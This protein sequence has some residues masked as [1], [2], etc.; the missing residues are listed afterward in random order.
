MTLSREDILA[1]TLPTKIE[2]VPEWGGKVILQGITAAQR[3]AYEESMADRSPDGTVKRRNLHNLRAKLVVLCIVD[4]KY[5]RIFSDSDA[6]ALGAKDAAVI[7]RLW[8]V[9]RQLCGMSTEDER[10]LAEDFAKAQDVSSD[11]D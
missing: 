2:D 6:E 3:D 5:E 8:D 10:K 9:C 7:D 4:E 1:T 11:S